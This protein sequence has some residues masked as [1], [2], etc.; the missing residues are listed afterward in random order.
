MEQSG[1]VYGDSSA[2]GARHWAISSIESTAKE[3]REG[4]VLA[5]EDQRYTWLN[6][7]KAKDELRLV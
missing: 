1:R 7:V 6:R 3:K 2:H 5:R 4:R